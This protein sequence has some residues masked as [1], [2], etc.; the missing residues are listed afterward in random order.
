LITLSEIEEFG[1]PGVESAADL[2]P[3]Q[4]AFL[5]IAKEE[6]SHQQKRKYG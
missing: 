5:Q 2:T 1:L 6:R 3:L 4:S